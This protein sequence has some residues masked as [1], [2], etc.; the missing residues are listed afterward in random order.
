MRA[1]EATDI[2][3]RWNDTDSRITAEAM[4]RD[5]LSRPWL[6]NFVTANNEKPVVIVGSIRNK[7]S[8]HIPVDAFIK[9]IERELINSDQVS[10]VAS[11]EQR[12]QIREERLDQQ[13]FASMETAK[14]LANETGA[15]YMMQGTINSIVDSFEGKKTVFYQVD[16]ELID[17]EKNTKVWMGDKKIKKLIEQDRYGW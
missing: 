9:D 5:V 6:G 15:D 12:E 16:L 4:V 3:G 8:E 1:D 2:S 10:F 11:S 7:S 14:Q 13:S 17:L